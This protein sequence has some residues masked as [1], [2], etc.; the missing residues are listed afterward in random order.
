[1]QQQEE[2]KL[3]KKI[4]PSHTEGSPYSNKAKWLFWRV[5]L[6]GTAAR[7]G[8]G[9]GT[10][11]AS[12]TEVPHNP[13]TVISSPKTIGIVEGLLSDTEEFILK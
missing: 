12:R 8:V 9:K 10:T 7:S 3:G 11:G 1:M 5:P 13:E 2:N 6:K 4:S